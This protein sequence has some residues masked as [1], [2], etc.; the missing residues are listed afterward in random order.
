MPEGV[1]LEVRTMPAFS[2]GG[3]FEVQSYIVQSY[4][5]SEINNYRLDMGPIGGVSGGTAARGAPPSARPAPS[6]G[7]GGGE[8]RDPAS[9]R[10][11]TGKYCNHEFQS[12]MV[13]I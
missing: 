4:Q 9:S 5:N 2:P 13:S 12:F 11:A 3:S 7:R 10:S 1:G 8:R 6:A